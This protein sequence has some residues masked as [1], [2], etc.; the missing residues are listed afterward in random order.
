[1]PVGRQALQVRVLEVKFISVS[2]CW[3]GFFLRAAS[4]ASRRC[5]E[6][7]GLLDFDPTVEAGE[8]E[9]GGGVDT[10]QL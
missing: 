4:E 5:H 9:G 8:A 7:C 6:S 10:R 1:M 3:Q 2:V